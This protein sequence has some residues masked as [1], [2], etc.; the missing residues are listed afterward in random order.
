MRCSSSTPARSSSDRARAQRH[1]SAKINGN[2]IK[3]VYVYSKPEWTALVVGKDSKLTKV[4]DLRGKKVAMV[5]G[6][7]PHIFAV[8]ALLAAGITDKDY[9]PVLVQQHA[10]GG[11]ALIRGDVDAWAGLDPM[12]AQHEI[13]DGARLLYRN[14]DANTWGI[15][16]AREEFIKDHPDLVKRVLSS[17]EEARKYSLAHYDELKKIFIG[18]TKLREDVVD[19]QLKERTGLTYNKIGPAQRDSIYEAGIALQ[20]GGVIPARVDVK[21]A[22]DD[23]IDDKYVATN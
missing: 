9:T 16:N 23:L 2:P 12:M 11:T 1:W 8:R 6:T 17:Y 21:K 13:L 19:K 5:R 15:L 18:V 14:P 22:L 3:S 10:D 20:K 7:D 4:A